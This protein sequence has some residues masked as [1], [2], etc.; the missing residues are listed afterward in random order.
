M[1]T[2][3]IQCTQCGQQFCYVC[4]GISRVSPLY[5]MKA[6][7]GVDVEPHSFLTLELGGECSACHSG[8]NTAGKSLH[9]IHWIRGQV[10]QS[11]LGWQRKVF[12]LHKE[13][14][15]STVQCIAYSLY[16]VSYQVIKLTFIYINMGK[17][18]N[19]GK[20]TL[21]FL[22]KTSGAKGSYLLSHWQ[23][24]AVAAGRTLMNVLH[25]CRCQR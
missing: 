2:V 5:A 20:G 14:N 22:Q 4:K 8:H 23:S 7:E 25:K 19:P 24:N 18:H 17:V 6:Y 21:E 3:V 12:C 11:W 15:D 9:Y 13:L 1:P 16:Q 10:D